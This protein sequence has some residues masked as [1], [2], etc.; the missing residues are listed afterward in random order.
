[1]KHPSLRIVGGVVAALLATVTPMHADDVQ[2]RINLGRFQLWHACQ[3]IDLLVES[4]DDDE[5]KMGL[6]RESITTT[7][8]SRLRAARLYR[9]STRPSPYLYVVI[10]ALPRDRGGD[11]AFSVRLEFRKHF[12]DRISYRAGSASTW[13]TGAVGW[14]DAAYI[15]SGVSQLM[16]EFIDEYLR[17]NESACQGPGQD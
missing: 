13:D 10:N 8:R 2:D 4:P 9:E 6:T 11:T 3:P 14:G 5:V 16:D 12:F 1:M 7:V 15:L 17:V